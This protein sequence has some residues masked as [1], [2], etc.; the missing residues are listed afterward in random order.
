[1]A[2]GESELGNTIDGV[3][4]RQLLDKPGLE[5]IER[6]QDALIFHRPGKL[7]SA[8]RAGQHKLFVKWTVQGQIANRELYRV[9]EN[10]TE[11][12]NDIAESNPDLV[13]KL[14]KTLLD[15]L[16]SV[17]AE[18]PKPRQPKKRNKKGKADAKS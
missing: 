10:P 12:G 9:D 16:D 14:E 8:I 17:D 5:S 13:K 18:K 15:Y 4:F 6:A 7:E 3:S 1:M 2:G 11:H